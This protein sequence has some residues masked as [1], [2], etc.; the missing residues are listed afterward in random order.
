MLTRF[1]VKYLKLFS[2]IQVVNFLSNSSLKV[3]KDFSVEMQATEG[4]RTNRKA[5]WKINSSGYLQWSFIIHLLLYPF[6]QVSS[7]AWLSP[8][9]LS[10]SWSHPGSRVGL[11]LNLPPWPE[12]GLEI[13]IRIHLANKHL[14]EVCWR[15]WGKCILPNLGVFY[16]LLVVVWPRS[17]VVISYPASVESHTPEGEQQG[18]RDTD[19]VNSEICSIF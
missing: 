18:A 8:R 6:V 12:V 4:V 13:V 10:G 5:K 15:W 1:T 9:C 2:I 7:H 16:L 11:W 14:G 17:S 19:N 3:S